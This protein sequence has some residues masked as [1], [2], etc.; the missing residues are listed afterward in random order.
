M[1]VRTGEDKGATFLSPRFWHNSV[2]RTVR[3][4]TRMSSDDHA[5]LN[6]QVAA[7]TLARHRREREEVDRYLTAHAADAR[8]GSVEAV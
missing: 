7:A 3:D 2:T 5:R 8:H 4:L 1:V 6:A